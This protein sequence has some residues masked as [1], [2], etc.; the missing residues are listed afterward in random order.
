MET[1]LDIRMLRWLSLHLS[2][3]TLRPR[4]ALREHGQMG[5]KTL[6]MQSKELILEKTRW[7]GPVLC[8]VGVAE[9][10]SRGHDGDIKT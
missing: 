8:E 7:A 4:E 2:T 1:I 6:W 3:F 10:G 9:E 5:T